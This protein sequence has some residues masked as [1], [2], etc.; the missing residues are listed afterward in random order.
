[1]GKQIE[2]TTDPIVLEFTLKRLS[3]K[4]GDKTMLTAPELATAL[5]LKN[6]ASVYNLISK[7]T[8]GKFQIP[9]RRIGGSVR[10]NIVDIAK[11]LSVAA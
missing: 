10:F 3:E 5:G 2:I 8:K 1:M 9:V 11:Y 4:F 6:P 7:K